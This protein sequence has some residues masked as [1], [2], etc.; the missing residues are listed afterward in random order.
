MSE[1]PFL[2]QKIKLYIEV[3]RQH[4]LIRRKQDSVLVLNWD[5]IASVSINK[6]ILIKMVN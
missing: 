5:C 1:V 4:M 6:R 3:R 2:M